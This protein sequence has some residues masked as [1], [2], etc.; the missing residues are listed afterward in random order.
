[1]PLFKKKS[2]KSLTGGTDPAPSTAPPAATETGP[3]NVGNGADTNGEDDEFLEYEVVVP[4]NARIGSK[5]KMTVPSGEKVILVVPPGADPGTTISFKLKRSTARPSEDQAAVMIQARLRGKKARAETS[6]LKE[7]AA[8]AA[9]DPAKPPQIGAMGSIFSMSMSMI[10]AVFGAEPVIEELVVDEP[11]ELN[12]MLSTLASDVIMAWETQDFDSFVSLALP[13]VTVA[14]PG[15]SASGY[16]GVW[17]VAKKEAR[18]RGMLSLDSVMVQLENAAGTEAMCVAQEHCHEV[19]S[20]GMPIAHTWLKMLMKKVP[21][22]DEKPEQASEGAGAAARDPSRQRAACEGGGDGRGCVGRGARAAAPRQ[23]RRP[24]RAPPA[25]ARPCPEPPRRGTPPPFPPPPPPPPLLRS[26]SSPSWCATRSGR[27]PPPAPRR[28]PR[29]CASASAAP[30]Q[31][32]RTSAR[33]P[34]PR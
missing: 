33:S 15:A 10:T 20:H 30:P 3:G 31:L 14:V 11:D 1:M 27:P 32:R 25:T 34:T 23:R 19:G 12:L 16:Q 5:L 29:A 21:A 13:S 9:G 2:S 24:R 4:P 22:T 26:G 8:P 18:T 7:G 28:R 17:E 6:E